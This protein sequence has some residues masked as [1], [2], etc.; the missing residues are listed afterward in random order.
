MKGLIIGEGG[1]G[2]KSVVIVII[3][4]RMM[5]ELNDEGHRIDAV[6]T[7]TFILRRRQL[8]T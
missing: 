5:S 4:L 8:P 3:I 1:L 2:G 6:S 7:Q